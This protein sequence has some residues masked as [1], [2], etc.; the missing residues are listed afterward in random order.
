[1]QGHHSTTSENTALA[2]KG[3]NQQ[4]GDNKKKEGKKMVQAL[5]EDRPHNVEF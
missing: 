1:M 2:T 4:E 3:L 5:Q